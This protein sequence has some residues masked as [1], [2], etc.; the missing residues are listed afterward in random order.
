[1][2]APIKGGGDEAARLV[3]VEGDIQDRGLLRAVFERF[4]IKAVIHFAG[5]RA[6]GVW[7]V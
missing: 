1:M 7:R 6:V 2:F 5:L 3:F 4:E